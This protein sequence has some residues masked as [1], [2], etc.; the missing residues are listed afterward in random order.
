VGSVAP[1]P[2]LFAFL[3]YGALETPDT[4]G[5]ISYA[6]QLRAWALPS[7][8][9]LLKEAPAPISLFRTPQR[10]LQ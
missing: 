2:A 9:A 1:L 6:E 4:G 3:I 7:G 8:I 10:L 5:Y